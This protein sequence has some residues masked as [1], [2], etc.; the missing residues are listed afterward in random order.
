[1]LRSI[2][3]LSSEE[4]IAVRLL[5]RSVKTGRACIIYVEIDLWNVHFGHEINLFGNKLDPTCDNFPSTIYSYNYESEISAYGPN[6]MSRGNKII[7][8]PYQATVYKNHDYLGL[9]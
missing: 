2:S 3:I 7:I 9:L 1:M 8:L 5:Q 4:S 6:S